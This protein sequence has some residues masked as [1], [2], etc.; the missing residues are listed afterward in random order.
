MITALSSAGRPIEELARFTEAQLRIHYRE[1]QRRQYAQRADLVESL[2]CVLTGK[3]G[4]LLKDLR[5]AR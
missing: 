1:H 5:S 2:L 3:G 4:A